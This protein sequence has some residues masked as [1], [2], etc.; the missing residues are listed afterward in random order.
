MSDL[1]SEQRQ[2]LY[3]LRSHWRSMWRE[4]ATEWVEHYGLLVDKN[5]ANNISHEM[6]AAYKE[7]VRNL[8]DVIHAS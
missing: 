5:F 2:K 6:D 4:K 3:E 7:I 1:S 8:L